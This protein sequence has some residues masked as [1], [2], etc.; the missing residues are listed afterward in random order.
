MGVQMGKAARGI[1][2]MMGYVM[3]KAVAYPKFVQV[4]AQITYAQASRS[5]EEF[6]L[7]LTD[8]RHR[9]KVACRGQAICLR[10]FE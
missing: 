3:G 10:H 2:Q 7:T 8:H 5:A 1:Q 4:R 6:C 9:P